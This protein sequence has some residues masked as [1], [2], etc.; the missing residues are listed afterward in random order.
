MSKLVSHIYATNTQRRK[1][2]PR[3][4]SA[5]EVQESYLNMAYSAQS[6]MN[7]LSEYRIGVKLEHRVMLSDVEVRTAKDD[8]LALAVAQV[9]DAI[10]HEV[11]GEFR[12]HFRAVE[13]ALWG[14]DVEKAQQALRAFEK[15]MFTADENHDDTP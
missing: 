3:P 7:A 5:I 1:A 9:K 2:Y 14:H 8:V 4:L 6:P 13:M 12:E 15:Q 11:F 10:I